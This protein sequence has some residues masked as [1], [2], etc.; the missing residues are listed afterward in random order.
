MNET[1]NAL[2]AY[3]DGMLQ[4]GYSEQTVFKHSEHGSVRLLR[5]EKTGNALVE[6]LS[7]NRNDEVFRR[8][9]G[10]RL[11]HLP[12]IYEVCSTET[13]LLVL[14]EYIPGRRLSDVLEDGPLEQKTA[15]AYAGQLCDALDG[16]HRNGIIHR[17]IKPSNILLKPDGTVVLIDLSIARC[18]LGAK[19]KDTQM[20]GTVG[21][22]APEQ[23]GLSQSGQA[24]DIYGMG[25]LLNIM[26]TG[27]HP[28]VG[29][30]HGPL[31]RVVKKATSTQMTN[32]YQSAQAMKR[33]I[34]LLG[35][36]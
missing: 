1:D 10:K 3:I 9:R 18:L 16:L 14:E 4:K 17:D 27:V 22:A 31:R 26:L 13:H 21:Y 5:H 8:L 35:R 11:A 36:W 20:L 2:L 15:C 12:C 33:D 28:T 19:A 7:A 24:T 23:F 30:P 34:R 29:L 25:V 6:I 32:R